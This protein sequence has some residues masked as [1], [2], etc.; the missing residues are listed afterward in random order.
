MTKNSSNHFGGI[1]FLFGSLFQLETDSENKS[2]LN[3]MKVL[4]TGL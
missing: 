4:N 1:I 3:K 2:L